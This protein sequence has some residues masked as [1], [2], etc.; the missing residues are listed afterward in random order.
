MRF[1]RTFLLAL[2]IFSVLANK[3]QNRRIDSL[4]KLLRSSPAE[5]SLKAYR[6][7]ALARAYT[8]V[9]A[10]K[11][12]MCAE[13]AYDIARKNDLKDAI[14]DA[15]GTKSSIYMGMGAFDKSIE[16]LEGALAVTDSIKK[17]RS[18]A[19]CLTN[20][21]LNYYYKGDLAKALQHLLRAAKIFEDHHDKESLATIYVNAGLIY[22][23]QNNPETALSFYLKALEQ[24]REMGDKMVQVRCLLNVGGIYEAQ[25]K[26][27]EAMSVY[28][29]G[30]LLARQSDD[31]NGLGQLMNNMGLLYDDRGEA[32]SALVYY[33]EALKYSE[34]SGDFH[35]LAG[36]YGNIGYLLRAQGKTREALEYMNKSLELSKESGDKHFVAEGFLS[37]AELHG[38]LRDYKKAYEYAIL[39]GKTKDTLLNEESSK[40]LIEM[41]TKYETGKKDNEIKILSKDKELQNSQ[42]FIQKLVIYAAAIVLLLLIAFAVSIRRSYRQKQRANLLLESRNQEILQQKEIIEE[43]NKDILDS[44]QYAR[45]IQHSLLPTQFYIER[46]LNKL[47]SKESG[48]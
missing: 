30:I 47:K 10:K 34:A 31:I 38:E 12:I 14:G 1:C 29:E 2:F 20:I 9:D 17:L 15:L 41:E 44:I 23:A 33:R 13:R 40:S 4:Q 19:R 5:D 22:S 11:G 42:L 28:R 35:A 37:L 16:A 21:G 26:A 32:D 24:A 3:A 27:E 43:K 48:S 6:Y 25:K 45:R 46:S 18:Y 36:I 7:L 8:N 39:Y